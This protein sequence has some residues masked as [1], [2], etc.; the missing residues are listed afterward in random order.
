MFLRIR[1]V[2]IYP[3]YM[4]NYVCLFQSSLLS[5]VSVRGGGMGV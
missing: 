3:L 4:N 5:F 1:H 2:V